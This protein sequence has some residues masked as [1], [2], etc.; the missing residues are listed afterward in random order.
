VAAGVIEMLAGNPVAAESAFRAGYD[1]LAAMDE[2]GFLSTLAVYL[3]HALYAQQRI[4]EAEQ[5]AHISREATPPP[6]DVHP[7]VFI[8]AALAKI[9]ASRGEHDRAI[10][11]GREAVERADQSD[12]FIWQADARMD[13][14]EVLRLAAR[15]FDAAA[16]AEEAFRLYEQKGD[17]VSA[18]R[19][20]EFRDELVVA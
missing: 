9:F 12:F 1:A 10:R 8:Q 16:A 11:L 5:F 4:D 18:R 6:A 13:V 15:P 7:E 20:R 19:A 17:V 14:A 3:S 2:R